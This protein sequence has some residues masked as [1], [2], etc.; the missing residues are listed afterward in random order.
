MLSSSIPSKTVTSVSCSLNFGGS[1]RSLR[2]RTYQINSLSISTN[3]KNSLVNQE[4][5]NIFCI[6]IIVDKRILFLDNDLSKHII[7]NH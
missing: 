1:R 6:I 2:S 4:G 5:N 3:T 7:N